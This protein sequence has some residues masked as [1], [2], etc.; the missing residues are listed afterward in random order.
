MVKVAQLDVAFVGEEQVLRAQ[1]AVRDAALV[2]VAQ[3]G[4]QLR[5]DG[6]PHLL[7]LQRVRPRQR[8]LPQQV[9]LQEEMARR[10]GRREGG[11]EGAT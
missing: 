2:Q 5:Q 1:V 10:E 9:A 4:Q 11:G 6:L 8:Q 7:L 3:R